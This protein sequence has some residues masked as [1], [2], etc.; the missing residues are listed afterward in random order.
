MN[1]NQNTTLQKMINI[2]KVILR[3]NSFY[4]NQENFIE[5]GEPLGFITLAV[6][7]IICICKD[8]HA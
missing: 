4:K 6:Y 8:L 5:P 1:W 2:N 7:K 3:M